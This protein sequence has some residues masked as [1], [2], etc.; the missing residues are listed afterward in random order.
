MPTL[1][2]LILLLS[3]QPSTPDPG[4]RAFQRCA[5]CHSLTPEDHGLA[6]PSLSGIHGRPAATSDGY[7]YSDAL[8][9]AGRHGLVWTDENLDRFLTDPEDAV[10]G[11][12]MPYQG[13]TAAERQAVIRFLKHRA[14]RP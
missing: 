9:R 13:G 11:T 6:G 5:A 10:P 4:E 12:T 7:A 1:F 3:E 2:F 8:R 14:V